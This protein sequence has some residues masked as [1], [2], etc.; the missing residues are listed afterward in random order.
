MQL[1][2]QRQG[3]VVGRHLDVEQHDVDAV[4]EVQVDVHHL[5]R[6]RSVADARD[7]AHRGDVVAAEDAHRRAGGRV[8]AAALRAPF[9]VEEALH[10]RQEADELV[11]VTLVEAAGGAVVL[12]EVLAPRRRIAHRTQ[13]LP[14][15]RRRAVVLR[16][17]RRD[18][19]QRPEQRLAQV[20]HDHLLPAVGIGGAR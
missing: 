13:R 19:A 20:P 3:Q 9:A 8:A 14:G 17:A 1:L 12:V 11:V 10:V 16:H 7:D 5:Q 6:D 2:R 15:R 18:Q 4:E